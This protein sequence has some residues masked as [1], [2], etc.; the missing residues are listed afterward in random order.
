MN[1]LIEEAHCGDTFCGLLQIIAGGLRRESNR[2]AQNPPK[3]DRTYFAPGT[4]VYQ[5]SVFSS[6]FFPILS[7]CLP[8]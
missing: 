8:L 3:N 7:T 5:D 1:L 6:A 2:G 4:G